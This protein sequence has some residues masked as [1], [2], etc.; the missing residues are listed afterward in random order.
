MPFN[1]CVLPSCKDV[2]RCPNFLETGYLFL[3]FLLVTF[4]AV[5]LLVRLDCTVD[6]ISPC[7]PQNKAQ[8]EP[9][10]IEGVCNPLT[11]YRPK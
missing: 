1:F 2:S 6:R 4:V 5:E 11:P 9:F 8:M 10:V 3:A 7:M